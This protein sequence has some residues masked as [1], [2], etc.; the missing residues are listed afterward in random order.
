M[1]GATQTEPKEIREV[2]LS[3]EARQFWERSYL[4]N[5]PRV[6]VDISLARSASI[7]AAKLADHALDRWRER[8]EPKAGE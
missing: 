2:L 4:A 6:F 5:E 1:T 3:V 7:E 8:F